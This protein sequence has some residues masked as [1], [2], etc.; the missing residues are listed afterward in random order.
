R[1]KNQIS[2]PVKKQRVAELTKL[3]SELY[4]EFVKGFVGK[5]GRV[6]FEREADGFYTGHN[7]EYIEVKVISDKDL[8]HQFFTVK[9][10][11]CDGEYLMGHVIEG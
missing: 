4:N 10:D 11:S 7:S 6:L 3:S 8:S 2:G 5:T 1:M 9:Y